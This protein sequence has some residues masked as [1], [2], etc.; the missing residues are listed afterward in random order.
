MADFFGMDFLA[1]C[2]FSALRL[3]ALRRANFAVY[4]GLI[5]TLSTSVSVE[6]D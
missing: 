1:R 2:G 3:A 6:P 4:F 5:G